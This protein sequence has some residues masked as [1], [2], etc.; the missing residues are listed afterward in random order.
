MVLGQRYSYEPR[1]PIHYADPP[2]LLLDRI[3]L[4]FKLGKGNSP[5]QNMSLLYRKDKKEI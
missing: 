5:V 3:I 2:D 4:I 1:F